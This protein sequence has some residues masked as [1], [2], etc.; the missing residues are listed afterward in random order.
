[1]ISRLKIVDRGHTIQF[2]PTTLEAAQALWAKNPL[3]KFDDKQLGSH[4]VL[5]APKSGAWPAGKNLDV[6]LAKGAP[7]REGPR[8][9]TRDSR[10]D[11]SVVKTFAVRGIDCDYTDKPRLAT[12]CPE[13]SSAKL[14]F[15]TNL[16]EKAFR[17][18]MIQ[19]AGRP[20]QDHFVNGP[21]VSIRVPPGVGKTSQIK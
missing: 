8:L 1:M 10:R 14:E 11:F 3:F 12:T 20:L 6:F 5:L 9:L 4:Y 18:E 2:T 7:S 15:T 17:A 16:D 13:E 19:T 21:E